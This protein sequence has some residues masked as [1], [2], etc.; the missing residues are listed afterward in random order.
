M[1]TLAGADSGGKRGLS[2]KF[3]AIVKMAGVD[4][5]EVTRPN[6]HKFL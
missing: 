6:G 2:R 1:P 3:K 5:R 4:F